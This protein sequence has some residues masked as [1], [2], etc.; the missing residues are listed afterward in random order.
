LLEVT[1]QIVQVVFFLGA[2]VVEAVLKDFL[3]VRQIPFVATNRDPK[4]NH[5]VVD[6]TGRGFDLLNFFDVS[7]E[8]CPPIPM[9]NLR[10]KIIWG[11]G[12]S[13]LIGAFECNGFRPR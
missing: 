13:E 1:N 5:K 2:E 12:S 7:H 10:A 6:A 9:L 11:W 4:G 8:W 3:N